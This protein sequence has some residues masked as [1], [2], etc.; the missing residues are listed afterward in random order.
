M[1]LNVTRMDSKGRISI[2]MALRH[3]MRFSQGDELT[4][5]MESN[6]LRLSPVGSGNTELKIKFKK[7][8]NVSGALSGVMR[9]LSRHRADIINSE[10]QMGD[11]AGWRA[12]INTEDYKQVKSEIEELE[13]VKEFWIKKNII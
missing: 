2:P 6:E 7:S 10:V 1:R 9:V 11:S 8:A 4:L 3:H 12:V 5:R 13:T